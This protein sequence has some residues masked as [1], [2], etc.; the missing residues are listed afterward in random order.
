[1]AFSVGTE[2][3]NLEGGIL[4]PNPEI[5]FKESLTAEK[6]FSGTSRELSS[7]SLMIKPFTEMFIKD[8]DVNTWAKYNFG[9]YN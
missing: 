2:I 3:G 4:T 5:W 8:A 6:V 7:W 1:M 9:N